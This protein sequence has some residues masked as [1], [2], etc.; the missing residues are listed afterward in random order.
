[1]NDNLENMAYHHHYHHNNNQRKR[2]P[3]NDHDMN[4]IHNRIRSSSSYRSIFIYS[5]FHL[6]LSSIFIQVN[7][8]FIFILIGLEKQKY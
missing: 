5:I 1:M 3:F 7:K 2:H 8:L 4:M 6:F